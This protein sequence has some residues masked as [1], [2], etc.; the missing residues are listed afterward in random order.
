MRVGVNGE[1]REKTPRL[2][3][4][5]VSFRAQDRMLVLLTQTVCRVVGGFERLAGNISTI[6]GQG[7]GGGIHQRRD[8]CA[9]GV[10]DRSDERNRK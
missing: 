2:Y 1:G 6:I 10:E 7:D 3:D 4:L 8:V 5:S 9:H